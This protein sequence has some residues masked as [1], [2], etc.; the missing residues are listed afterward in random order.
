MSFDKF[1]KFY[2]LLD[3]M[4]IIRQLKFMIIYMKE[5]TFWIKIFSFYFR[6]EAT[7]KLF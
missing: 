4:D 6:I 7:T 5:V 2:V 1:H 3:A